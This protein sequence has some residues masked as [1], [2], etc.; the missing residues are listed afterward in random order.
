MRFTTKTEYGLVSLVYMAK[1]AEFH[2]VTIKEIVQGE[3]YSLSFTEKILQKLR[4][5]GIVKS[6]QGS[7]GGYVLARKA[8]EITLK[9]IIEALE[10][11]TFEVFCEPDF[12]KDIVCTH[13]SMCEVKPVW[14][15]TKDLLDGFFGSITL[16]ML[17]KNEMK[18]STSAAF[19]KK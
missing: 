2:P 6:Q 13:H 9:E 10:G 19:L 7:H 12:R 8:T 15:K 1:H 16:D 18:P 4:S 3:Q 17:T 14:Q 11:Q 5:A